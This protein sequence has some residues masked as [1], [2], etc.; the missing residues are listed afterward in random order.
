MPA[1]LTEGS[2][3]KCAHQ[4]TVSTSGATKLKVSGRNVLTV[5]GMGSWSVGSDCTQKGTNMKQCTKVVPPPASGA[6][7]KLRVQG[8]P[9]VLA[10][11]SIITDGAPAT[12]PVTAQAANQNKLV[13]S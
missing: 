7:T 1:V 2:S 11:L 6:S 9:V 4:G 5:S 10:S 12:G 13:A 3:L 8:S